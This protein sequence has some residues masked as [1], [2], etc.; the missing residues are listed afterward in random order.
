MVS[1]NHG[2]CRPTLAQ[3]RDRIRS[4]CTDCGACRI[5]CPFL[6]RYGTPLD[7]VG[8]YD[9]STP[10]HQ[11]IAFECNLC[12][13]CD[14][15]CPAHVAPCDLFLAVR[16]QADGRPDGKAWRHLPVLAYETWGMSPLLS[17]YALP[18]GCDT[19]FFP[20]CALPGTR[21]ETTWRLF[22]HLQHCIPKLGI[23]LDCCTKPSHDLGRQRHFE[24]MFGEMA[25]YLGA[26]GIRKVL[27]ACPN[28]HTI[29]K[30]YGRN[31]SVDTVYTTVNRSA[32]PP[33]A[34]GTGELAIHDPCSVRTE[35]AVQ[36][37]VRGLLSRMGL[38]ATEM[39]HHRHHT[40]CCGEGGS[41]G[42]FQP[43][44]ARHWSRLRRQEAGG[45]KLVTYC[46]GCA[47]RL[48]RLTPTVHIADL[49]FFPGQALNGGMPVTR[50]PHTYANRWKLKQRFERTLAPAVHGRRLNFSGTR[51]DFV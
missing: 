28:C 46:T 10:A 34:S 9:F 15:V 26:N 47:D 48:S 45:R 41:V 37:A 1:G 29:F 3:V 36:D 33:R 51:I 43:D 23:V 49:L 21:P 8:R 7:I 17:Y 16:R 19:V 38:Q 6:Q 27:V 5:Q 2:R 22:T 50:P 11:R 12:R 40:L 14:A 31:L 13:L 18:D 44:L 42:L 39:Q 24:D 25:R 20:G 32:L 4:R 30:Q 35:T